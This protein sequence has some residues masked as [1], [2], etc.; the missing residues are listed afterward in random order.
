MGTVTSTYYDLYRLTS[1]AFPP[2][3]LKSTRSQKEGDERRTGV[4]GRNSR[5]MAVVLSLVTNSGVPGVNAFNSSSASLSQPSAELANSLERD[6]N[7]RSCSAYLS[8]STRA[9]GKVSDMPEMASKWLATEL[10]LHLLTCRRGPC[11]SG[12]SAAR[13]QDATRSSSGTRRPALARQ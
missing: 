6:G 4:V 12:E 1:L 8:A 11:F 13:I 10:S 7:L 5:V 3:Q 2:V 9:V